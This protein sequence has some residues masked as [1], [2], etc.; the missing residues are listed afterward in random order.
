MDQKRNESQ[1]LEDALQISWTK[2]IFELC[3]CIEKP[4]VRNC[5]FFGSPKRPFISLTKDTIYP[6]LTFAIRTT[7]PLGALLSEMVIEV[8]YALLYHHTHR[9]NTSV[10]LAPFTLAIRTQFERGNCDKPASVVANSFT[11]Q[12]G[13]SGSTA[14]RLSLQ[15]QSFV[16]M[17]KKSSEHDR[18]CSKIV[19]ADAIRQKFQMWFELLNRNWVVNDDVMITN[20]S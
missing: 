13:R 19:K 4:R 10:S 16:Y 1:I 9:E 6:T 3:C 8:S 14:V 2:Q 20:C 17:F 18:R 15:W 11:L 12:G 7:H 5:D